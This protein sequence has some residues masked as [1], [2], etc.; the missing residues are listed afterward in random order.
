MEL[1]RPATGPAVPGG[2]GGAR[3]MD[4]INAA[5]PHGDVTQAPAAVA[6]LVW[7]AR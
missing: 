3:L 1:F 7:R 2:E 6:W 5:E 4:A